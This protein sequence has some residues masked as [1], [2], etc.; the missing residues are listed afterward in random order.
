MPAAPPAPS[1]EMPERPSAP[2][3]K[4]RNPLVTALRAVFR[5][6]LAI[7]I[8]VDE[9]V[10]PLYTPLQR[11][12]AALALV[13]RFERWVASL[14]PLAILALIGVPYAVVEPVK[15]V[16]LLRIADGHVK[17]GSLV[18][19][20]AYLVSFVLIERVYTAGRPQLMTLP[21]AAWVIRLSAAV[22]EKL[23]I[24]LR[25]PELRARARVMWRWLRLH[26]R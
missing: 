19:L 11:W 3:A 12:I 22:R 14:P 8:I 6:V 17:M 26:L 9:L 21:A 4:R 15:F 1:A 10:R 5:V 24:W 23:S 2:R 16:A 25:L 13:Q 7:L 20:L 18:L